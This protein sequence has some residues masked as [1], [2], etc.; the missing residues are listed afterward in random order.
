MTLEKKKRSALDTVIVID[1]ETSLESSSD[2]STVIFPLP[3]SSLLQSN[4]D[5]E[6]SEEISK[7]PIKSSNINN[8]GPFQA[9]RREKVRFYFSH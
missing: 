1:E 4:A 3:S 9:K 7:T 6:G 2:E 5:D 8:I